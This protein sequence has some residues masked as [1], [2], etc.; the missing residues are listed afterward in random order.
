MWPPCCAE[1]ADMITTSGISTE[2]VIY[3]DHQATTPV[4]PRVLAA[5]LPS[6]TSSY[7]NPSSPHAYG[8][9]GES[10]SGAA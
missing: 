3:L 6:L 10:K 4:D 1:W 5:M 2:E 7:G 8:R 9:Q